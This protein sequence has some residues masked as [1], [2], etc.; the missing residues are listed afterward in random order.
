[1]KSGFQVFLILT[2]PSKVKKKHMIAL[3]F[4]FQVKGLGG[5]EGKVDKVRWKG[6]LRRK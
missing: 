2:Q 1:M 3:D 4:L 5:G 6:M